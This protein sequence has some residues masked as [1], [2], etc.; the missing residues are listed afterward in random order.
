MLFRSQWAALLA[1]AN[2]KRGTPLNF[3]TANAL[4][5]EAAKG[6]YSRRYTDIVAGSNDTCALCVAGAGYDYISGLGTPKASALVDFLAT[7]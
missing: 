3:N 1:V 4:L 2:S 6:Q 5:Y 7:H